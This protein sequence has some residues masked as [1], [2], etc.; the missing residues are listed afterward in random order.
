MQ[1]ELIIINAHDD[2]LTEILKDVDF[3]IESWPKKK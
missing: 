2:E 1:E 3:R